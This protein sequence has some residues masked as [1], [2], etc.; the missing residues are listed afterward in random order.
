MCGWLWNEWIDKLIDELLLKDKSW[1]YQRLT[2]C[3][4]NKNMK[5][6]WMTMNG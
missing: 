5:N 3:E 1:M 4:S 2:E 6:E